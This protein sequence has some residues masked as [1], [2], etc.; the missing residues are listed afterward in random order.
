MSTVK[1]KTDLD[2]KSVA[3]VEE[4]EILPKDVNFY[5]YDGTLVHSYTASEFLMHNVM[6]AFPSHKGLKAQEW[7]WSIENA[8]V[9]VS[10]YGKLDIGV[11]YIT[12]DGKTRIYINII[13]PSTLT[14]RV[15]FS[16]I[17]TVIVDWG[18]GSNTEAITG[19]DLG[20]TLYTNEHTFSSIGKY[21][22][23]LEPTAGTTLSFYYVTQDTI[24]IIMPRASYHE[25]STFC[26]RAYF[27]LI[28][29]IEFGN[30]IL[31]FT[32]NGGNCTFRSLWNLET[33]TIPNTIIDGYSQ[34]FQ[35]CGKLKC[36]I[37]PRCRPT[38]GS[39][40][41]EL[42][43]GLTHCILP[44]STTT[45]GGSMAKD[46]RALRSFCIPFN[47]TEIKDSAFESCYS[48]LSLIIPDSVTAI[49]S[50][51]LKN[52]QGLHEIRFKPTTPP[53][54]ANSST[55]TNI[56][57]ICKIYVPTG[58]LSAYTSATNYPDPSTYTYIEE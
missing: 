1:V 32:V 33:V 21:V 47:T 6:P 39:S 23:S 16:A 3:L 54:V 11:T 45:V 24:S 19:S 53:T 25:A 18:D 36:I 35:D 8:R 10:K 22:I 52:C 9:H 27:G 31:N 26:R 20:T 51:V 5:D 7:N 2:W 44:D 48:L 43:F 14:M 34:I 57:S 28:E 42:G 12:D 50:S 55:F 29:K 58:S 15:A 38:S 49:G 40:L 17:G 37:I 4:S 41:C 13:D 30:R 56:T 46:C